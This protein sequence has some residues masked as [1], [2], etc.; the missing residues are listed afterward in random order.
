MQSP[1]T[2]P[3]AS[4]YFEQGRA[5]LQRG[6]AAAAIVQYRRALA[7]TSCDVNC[8]ADLALALITVKRLDDAEAVL[9]S[10]IRS[11]PDVAR[12][13]GH[14][15]H[16]YKHTG[17]LDLALE[18]AARAMELMPHPQLRADYA[19]LL[20]AVG[21]YEEAWRY[22]DSR[23][24]A[25]HKRLKA[26]PMPIWSGDSLETRS[27]FVYQEEA[28]GDAIQMLRYMPMLREQAASVSVQ[29]AGPLVR[30][31]RQSF[32]G[33]VV[34]DISAPIPKADFHCPMWSLPSRFG[35]TLENIPQP[36][37][38]AREIDQSQSRS[39]GSLNVGLVWAAG[40]AGSSRSMTLGTM[41]RL[42]EAASTAAFFSLQV[43]AHSAD[44][45]EC[46]AESLLADLSPRL[47][48][49]ADTAAAID[50]IDLVIT[51]DTSVAHLAGAMGRRC[52]VLLPFV[53]DSRW[54]RD[55]SDSP[56][57][58]SIRLFRQ[59][60]PGDWSEPLREVQEAL[61]AMV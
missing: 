42:C 28:L 4:T 16:V 39:K 30:L 24:D 29:V 7:L 58:P 31:V 36:P 46:G 35:T 32:P 51:V 60:R 23:L 33:I 13:H 53:S 3:D 2:R 20:L 22:H 14:L 38:L 54:M 45:A 17:R 10:A 25:V 61:E 50:E 49:F 8:Q 55:R 19:D 47:S 9:V 57:Y 18:S 34:A 27:I 44:I 48:D 41:L 52:F 11:A 21:R 56:W 59:K 6:H 26:L 1:K 15:A 43:G 12:L 5:L 40:P 37:Y